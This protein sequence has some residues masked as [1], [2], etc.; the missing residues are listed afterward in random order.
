[1]FD[2][3]VIEAGGEFDAKDIERLWQT[4]EYKFNHADLLQL[5]LNFELC[6]EIKESGKYIV[7]ELLPE[8]TPTQ[9]YPEGLKALT[10]KEILCFEYWYH[11]MPKG[12]ISRLI[13]RMNPSINILFF[14][15][16]Q[17]KIYRATNFFLALLT[18][19]FYNL[20]WIMEFIQMMNSLKG[21]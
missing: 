14:H 5:M 6:Y 21:Q 17:G 9:G 11:F 1:M 10:N 8:Q 3:T 19:I 2:N 7:P 4:K 16:I 13:V 12:I 18:K 15:A 20:I